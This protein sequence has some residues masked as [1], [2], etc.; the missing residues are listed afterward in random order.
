MQVCARTRP[1]LSI[2][3]LSRWSQKSVKWRLISTHAL[4]GLVARLV[5]LCLIFQS[6]LVVI[7]KGCLGR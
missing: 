5:R 2:P 7:W 6:I 3:C 1:Q 4:S